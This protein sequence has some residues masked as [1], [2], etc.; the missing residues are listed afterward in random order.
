MGYR[1]YDHFNLSP[2]AE[3]GK[4]LSYTTFAF[5][6]FKI[7]KNTENNKN[8]EIKNTET[9]A[10]TPDHPS[11]TDLAVTVRVSLTVAN[12]G[13]MAAKEVAQMYISFP[14]S[15]NEPPR[16]L[17]GFQKVMLTPGESVGVNFSLSDRDLSVFHPEGMKWVRAS[18]QFQ[19]YVGSSSRNLPLSGSF[20]L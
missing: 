19:V 6:D 8:T 20:T 5:K 7:N 12:T 9:N 10:S 4:G 11:T 18:G 13:A 14:A 16:Q 17:R 2:L 3:F 1:Y 15:Y